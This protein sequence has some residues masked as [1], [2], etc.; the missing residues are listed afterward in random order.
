M[1]RTM[2]TATSQSKKCYIVIIVIDKT[3]KLFCVLF[4]LLA[5]AQAEGKIEIENN[6]TGPCPDPIKSKVCLGGDVPVCCLETEYCIT[7]ACENCFS[8]KLSDPLTLCSSLEYNVALTNNPE[9]CASACRHLISQSQWKNGKYENGKSNVSET[10]LA[11]EI[12]HIPTEKTKTSDVTTEPSDS[13]DQSGMKQ[14]SNVSVSTLVT[15]KVCISTVK[16]RQS[17][18]TIGIVTL[19]MVILLILGYVVYKI[20]SYVCRKKKLSYNPVPNRESEVNKTIAI[21]QQGRVSRIRK[22]QQTDGRAPTS[23]SSN[24]PSVSSG[25]GVPDNGFGIDTVK[26]RGDGSTVSE[27]EI[28]DLSV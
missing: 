22:E 7:G 14:N 8:S 21:G 4:F 25:A 26:R 10:T 6:D 19:V 24:P 2:S 5:R 15:E 13:K 18:D 27:N 3:V 17:D 11:F 1:F 12:V 23:D 20:F 9:K 28:I 16:C